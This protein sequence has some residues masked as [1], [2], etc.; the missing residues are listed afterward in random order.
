LYVELSLLNQLG[1]QL[2]FR[3]LLVIFLL[4]TSSLVAQTDSTMRQYTGVLEKTNY[5]SI[6]KLRIL[7]NPDYFD[8]SYLIERTGRFEIGDSVIVTGYE[9]VSKREYDYPLLHVQ[10][11][12]KFTQSENSDTTMKTIAGTLR[13]SQFA[14]LTLFSPIG[15]STPYYIERTGNFEIG[16]DVVITSYI[17]ETR[18]DLRF[19]LLH[20]QFFDEY[21]CCLIEFR[22]DINL[23]GHI[24]LADVIMLSSYFNNHGWIPQICFE[25]LDINGDGKQN[26]EDSQFLYDFV[27]HCGPAPVACDMRE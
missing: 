24:N 9:K 6:V 25:S 13:E 21:N 18:R 23:D 5:A 3:L 8:F 12:D 17:K 19:P 10:S 15:G 27:M 4:T 20:V 22:G 1:K 16:D 2:P 26:K 11:I 14:T 7:F